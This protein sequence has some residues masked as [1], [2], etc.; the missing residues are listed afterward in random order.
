MKLLYQFLISLTI[1]IAVFNTPF[2]STI[3]AQNSTWEVV[4]N[5]PAIQ[6][7]T[8]VTLLELDDS[9]Y[10]LFGKETDTLGNSVT[11]P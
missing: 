2:L 1:L 10:V 6:E 5:T 9:T 3:K 4:S 11:A 7:S 8:N